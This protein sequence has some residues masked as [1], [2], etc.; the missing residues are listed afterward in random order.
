MAI[1]DPRCPESFMRRKR[2]TTPTGSAENGYPVRA[3]ND[4]DEAPWLTDSMNIR[5][6]MLGDALKADRA[7]WREADDIV[8][9]ECKRASPP[10][11]GSGAPTKALGYAIN[12]AN[13]AFIE[14]ALDTC[15]AFEEAQDEAHSCPA[16][17][18]S[19]AYRRLLRARLRPVS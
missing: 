3:C 1:G 11:P 9:V 2:Q 7:K 8:L 6:T 18:R 14:A 17:A 16:F 13:T 10:N 5:S 19:P 4:D 15:D 12:A